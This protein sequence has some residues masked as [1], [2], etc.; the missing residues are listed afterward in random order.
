MV[1]LPFVVVEMVVWL[2]GLISLV[3]GIGCDAYLSVIYCLH[4]F[5]YELFVQ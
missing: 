5:L 1:D 2:D 4:I 3:F